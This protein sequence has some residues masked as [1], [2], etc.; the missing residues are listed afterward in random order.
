MKK[1][2]KVSQK[3]RRKRTLAF[4]LFLLLLVFCACAGWYYW[5][6]RRLSIPD[7]LWDFAAAYPEAESFVRDY[8]KKKNKHVS[9]DI[10]EEVRASSVPL[11]IQWDERWGYRTYGSGCMGLTGC[12]PTCLSMVVTGLT[13]NTSYDPWYM[14]QFS[15]KQGYYVWGEGTSWDLMTEGAGAFGLSVE[16]GEISAEYILNHLSP[17]TPIICSMYP[18]D[19][20]RAGHFI[21]LR[22][23]DEN[24]NIY[25]NDP[26][27]PSHSSRAWTLDELLPQ[28][29]YLWYYWT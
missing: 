5:N 9:I 23:I 19:F 4:L 21:V 7:E 28:I 20:T 10:T 1:R 25:L 2:K 16:A 15:E 29:R 8:P 14:A 12:G 3:R 13:K 17:S 22:Q 24:G 11:F 18:G 6:S 26:N 27:S